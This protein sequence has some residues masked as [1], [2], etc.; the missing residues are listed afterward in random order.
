[1]QEDSRTAQDIN[2]MLQGNL[3]TEPLNVIRLL[4]AV[5][6]EKTDISMQETGQNHSHD[7]SRSSTWTWDAA[8]NPEAPLGRIR[9]HLQEPEHIK[10]LVNNIQGRAIQVGGDLVTLAL[11]NDFLAGGGV[12]PKNGRGARGGRP[13]ELPRD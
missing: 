2:L 3:G 8:N 5:V 1:M 12:R 10:Q 13:L 4:M 9:L 7:T 11:S 6:A